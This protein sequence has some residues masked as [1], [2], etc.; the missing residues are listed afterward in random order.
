MNFDLVWLV[1]ALCGGSFLLGA[2]VMWGVSR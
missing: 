1:L 2:L